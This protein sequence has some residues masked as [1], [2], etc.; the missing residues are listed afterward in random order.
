MFEINADMKVRIAIYDFVKHHGCYPN[1]IIMG[2]NLA[3]E[4]R[5]KYYYH[6]FP[7]R[8]YEDLVREKKLKIPCEFEGIPVDIDYENPNN[9][10]VGYMVKWLE[11]KH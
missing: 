6:Y 7:I 11:N 4:L 10:E 5:R 2:N 8:A 9:L 1:R 3:E